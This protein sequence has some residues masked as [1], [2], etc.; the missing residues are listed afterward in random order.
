MQ[1]LA[2][3]LGISLPIIQAPMRGVSTPS[4]AASVSE[5]GGLGSLGCGGLSAIELVGRVKATRSLTSKPINLNLFLHST[6][7][8]SDAQLEAMRRRLDHYRRELGLSRL[9]LGAT[10]SSFDAALVAALQELAPQV[11]SFHFGL[12][13]RE[14][15]KDL[16]ASGAFIMASATTVVEAQ[17]LEHG[18]VDAVIAQGVE[19]GG[20]RATFASDHTAGQIGLIALVPQVA[21]A[22]SVPV[23]AAGGIGDGRGVAAALI[24]GASAVQLGTAFLGCHESEVA[25]AYRAALKGAYDT[26]ITSVFS[27]R[28]ARAIVNRFIREAADIEGELLPFPTQYELTA[29][30]REASAAADSS[31]FIAMWAGQSA[32]MTN[33][34]NAADLVH[35]LAAEAA[36]L[37]ALDL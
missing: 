12:P 34:T 26:R 18:G 23:I 28:P 36:E 15:V 27:G 25:P 5:A 3:R 14:V 31:D 7:P 20:H 30:M 35:S 9:E 16:K 29:T 17:I 11:L 10:T 2:R 32:P 21:D 1:E 33:F 19:A 6:P 24:L 4:L 37:L 13:D 8:V 22:V